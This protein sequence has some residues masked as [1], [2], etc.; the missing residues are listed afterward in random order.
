MAL[1]GGLEAPPGRIMGHA[2]APANKRH[3]G[4]IPSELY[5]KNPD[6]RTKDTIAYLGSTRIMGHAGAWAAPGEPDAHT[7]YQALERAGAV[8]VNVSIPQ[9]DSLKEHNHLCTRPAILIS[10]QGL[11]TFAELLGVVGGLE[12]PPGRIMGHAGAWAAPGE[13]DAHTKYQ[14]LERASG[15]PGAAHA[16]ACPIIRPGGA[17]NPPTSAI[18][19]LW[20]V[21]P[22]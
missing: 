14:A 5:S 17:S 20:T 12:A 21:D 22:K 2:G 10:K 9:I 6:K 8:M 11:H 18:M 13:P 19:G 15:S 16:P 1:V 7:K 4:P 3:N